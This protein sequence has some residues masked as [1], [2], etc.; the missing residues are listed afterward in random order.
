M[1]VFDQKSLETVMKLSETVRN[2]GRSEAFILYKISGLKRSQNH[3]GGSSVLFLAK[4]FQ[5]KSSHINLKS[6][7][8]LRTKILI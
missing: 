6:F 5:E 2:V 7:K 3:G 1:S 8:I 4:I